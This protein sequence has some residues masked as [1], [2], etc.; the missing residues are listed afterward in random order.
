[1][2]N[3]YEQYSKSSHLNESAFHLLKDFLCY[4]SIKLLKQQVN[5]LNMI[6]SGNKFAV[7][8][9]FKFSIFFA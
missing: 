7:I 6:I 8:S 4:S 2:L 3:I 9:K 1:M 5:A